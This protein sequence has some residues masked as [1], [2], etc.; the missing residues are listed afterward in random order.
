MAFTGVS[1]GNMIKREDVEKLK[2]KEIQKEDREEAQ[3]AK[4]G[5][6]QSAEPAGKRPP[7]GVVLPPKAKD[8]TKAGVS[9]VP[10]PVNFLTAFGAALLGPQ[11]V[12]Q[13]GVQQQQ[14]Q[15]F[16]AQA[17][18][19]DREFTINTALNAQIRQA[20]LSAAQARA[21]EVQIR[22]AAK[23]Q[24]GN[25]DVV[26]KNALAGKIPPDL[27]TENTVRLVAE[28]FGWDPTIDGV[29][30]KIRTNLADQFA[31]AEAVRI[32][33]VEA[34]AANRALREV[35][36]DL[37]RQ[38]LELARDAGVRSDTRQQWKEMEFG[39]NQMRANLPSQ[40]S[41][42]YKREIVRITEEIAKI[43]AILAKKF[44]KTAKEV[45]KLS[46]S[47]LNDDFKDPA[48]KR[49]FTGATLLSVREKQ[50]ELLT[51]AK[52]YH[53]RSLSGELTQDDADAYH[54]YL[55]GQGAIFKLLGLEGD[56]EKTS[57]AVEAILG[58][59]AATQAFVDDN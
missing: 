43:D 15:Q 52:H 25:D 59:S 55:K 30:D 41:I 4:R 33:K 1:F 17:E 16:N 35:S 11:A 53:R 34:E 21:Q 46:D 32:E 47:Q 45:A 49:R 48:S 38:R 2:I 51:E 8:E 27:I 29:P 28:R 37:A 22:A 13:L 23:M 54:K 14:A 42:V 3:R 36:Q 20:E 7:I 24:D 58:V 19:R 31:Q 56:Q 26:V 9:Q 50:E 40:E 18:N 39:V 6:I 10:D 12:Q 57:N 44:N 5:E